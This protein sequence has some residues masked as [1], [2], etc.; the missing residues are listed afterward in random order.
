MKKEKV[1]KKSV[2]FKINEK[3]VK[4]PEVIHIL[5]GIG[6]YYIWLK[7]VFYLKILKMFKRNCKK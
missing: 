6:N 1:F 3:W 4:W 2:F 7:K 5:A